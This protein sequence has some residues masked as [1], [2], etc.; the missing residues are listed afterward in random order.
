M[1]TL[2]EAGKFLDEKIIR[3]FHFAL[4]ESGNSGPN[5]VTFHAHIELCEAFSGAFWRFD[6]EGEDF[7]PAARAAVDRARSERLAEE[8]AAAVGFGEN[9]IPF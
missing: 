7:E 5:A 1:M 4:R 3:P 9:D 6:V 8:E 2:R